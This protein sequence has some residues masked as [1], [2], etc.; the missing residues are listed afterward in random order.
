MNKSGTGGKH[1]TMFLFSNLFIRIKFFH[2][3]CVR[4]GHLQE[5]GRK[6]LQNSP[7]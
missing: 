3:L 6:M 2:V 4:H 1:Y 5:E 7:I